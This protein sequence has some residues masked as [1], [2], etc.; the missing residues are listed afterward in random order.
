MPYI[1]RAEAVALWAEGDPDVDESHV[2]QGDLF[3]SVNFYVP[4]K[5]ETVLYEGII[6]SYDC[7]YTKARLRPDKAPLSIAPVRAISAFS[8]EHAAYIRDGQVASAL[9]LPAHDGILDVESM[10][11]FRLLQPIVPN[12]LAGYQYVATLGPELRNALQA[13]LVEHFTRRLLLE[14]ES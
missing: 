4:H 9:Y 13:K 7:E 12:Q 11:D 3:H 6:V 1:G 14:D 2:F 8:E 5:D 10:V